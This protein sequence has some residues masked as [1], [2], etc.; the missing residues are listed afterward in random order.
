MHQ[1]E[2]N[3]PPH[4]VQASEFFGF[5]NFTGVASLIVGTSSDLSDRFAAPRP[6]D[7]FFLY[8]VMSHV[9]LL[10]V[11]IPKKI[12][13]DTFRYSFLFLSQD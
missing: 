3:K 7:D 2:T 12:V 9:F 10:Q 8:G 1:W 6:P 13:T 5:S 4:R 11:Q